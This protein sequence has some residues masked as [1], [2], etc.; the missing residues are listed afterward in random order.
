MTAGPI[1]VLGGITLSASEQESGYTGNATNGGPDVQGLFT[2]AQ[3]DLQAAALKLTEITA[4][5]PSGSNKTAIAAQ[6]TALTATS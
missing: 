1:S 5:L 6:L 3:Q 2:S 4:V